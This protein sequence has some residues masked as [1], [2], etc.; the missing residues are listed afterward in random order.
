MDFL[1]TLNDIEQGA[2]AWLKRA[3]FLSPVEHAAWHEFTDVVDYFVD[4]ESHYTAFALLLLRRKNEAC[5]FLVKAIEDK[6]PDEQELETRA[7]ED[8]ADRKNDERGM[9]E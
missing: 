7:W 3:K 9:Y 1:P 8:L 6:Q 4:C 2:E 5:D